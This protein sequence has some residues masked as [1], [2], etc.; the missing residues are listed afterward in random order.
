VEILIPEGALVLLV[1]VAGSGKSTFAAR[2][3]APTEILSSDRFRALVADDE[4]DQAASRAAFEVLHLVAA[5]RLA[6]RRLSVVDATNLSLRARRALLALAARHRRPAVAIVLD[7]PLATCRAR[8]AGRGRIVAEDVLVE[9]HR[10]LDEALAAMHDEPYA[11][12]H[13]LRDETEV[14]S[15]AVR[16]L[17]ARA[18]E[19]ARA[20]TGD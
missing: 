16:T 12:V 10:R 7:L 1:G 5:K 8:N 13:L 9:Q 14:E 18:G 2:H 17:S 4:A 3:F 19:T 15:V 11:A 6:R 20:S